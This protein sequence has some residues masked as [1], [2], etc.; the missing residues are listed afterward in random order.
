MKRTLLRLSFAL[1]MTALAVDVGDNLVVRY[2]IH[3]NREPFGSA[4]AG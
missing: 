2:R 3:A 1:V 4:R